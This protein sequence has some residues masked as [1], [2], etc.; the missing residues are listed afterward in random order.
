MEERSGRK[1]SVVGRMPL[2]T[3]Q[4]NLNITSISMPPSAPVVVNRKGLSLEPLQTN[5]EVLVLKPEMKKTGGSLS[6]SKQANIRRDLA[7]SPHI[8]E[9]NEIQKRLQDVYIKYE[10]DSAAPAAVESYDASRLVSL[11]NA[12]ENSQLKRV[13]VLQSLNKWFCTPD[14]GSV[15]IKDEQSENDESGKVLKNHEM[16]SVLYDA[17][18]AKSHLLDSLTHSFTTLE[19]HISRLNLGFGN[20]QSS[21]QTVYRMILSGDYVLPE[22]KPVVSGCMEDIR[23]FCTALE[24]D[25]SKVRQAGQSAQAT[26]G[27]V[28]DM[29][30]NVFQQ[31]SATKE[32]HQKRV[33]KDKE[34]SVRILKDKLENLEMLLEV[35]ERELKTM[36]KVNEK[37]K[38]RLE[39][40]II[41]RRRMS[42]SNPDDISM[43][44][45]SN[46]KTQQIDQV[47][48]PAG[49]VFLIFS[50]VS[51]ASR[52]WK[53]FPK[54]MT[55]ANNILYSI[56]ERICDEKSG[57]LVKQ[58]K[59][60]YLL[61]FTDALMAFEGIFDITERIQ[62]TSWPA[63]IEKQRREVLSSAMALKVCIVRGTPLVVL[64]RDTR[65]HEYI[66]KPIKRGLELLLQ[67]HADE[68]IFNERIG[69]DEVKN[70]IQAYVSEKLIMSVGNIGEVKIRGFIT[71]EN[72]LAL[73]FSCKNTIIPR[74]NEESQ[75]V[76]FVQKHHNELFQDHAEEDTGAY[77]HVQAV[78]PEKPGYMTFIALDIEEA[79]EF[80]KEYGE[81]KLI[82]VF[83][84]YSSKIESLVRKLG[85]Y[86]T[87]FTGT[88]HLF[89]AP[90]PIDAVRFALAVMDAMQNITLPV[91]FN[92]KKLLVR[93]AIHAGMASLAAN[94][95]TDEAQY[96]GT[97]VDQ[98]LFLC[99][100]AM[101]ED[102]L[103]TN[104]VMQEVL[105]VLT[106]VGS[107]NYAEWGVISKKPFT[108]TTKLYNIRSKSL[109]EPV[110][111]GDT[112]HSMKVT[113]S[114]LA[115]SEACFSL[116]EK[117]SS[118]V[119]SDTPTDEM[120]GPTGEICLVFTDVQD[121]TKLWEVYQN[122]MEKALFLHDDIMRNLID[123]NNGF[124]VKTEGD[125]FM[126]A[127][128]EPIDAL[129]WAM[130]AQLELLG[131]NWPEELL[132][133]RVESSAE[134]R[135][136]SGNLLYRGLRV[137]M[138]MH[139]G[140]PFCKL[141]PRTGRMDYFGPMVNRSARVSG[142]AQGGQ[143]VMSQRMQMEVKDQL[144]NIEIP[145]SMEL[146]GEFT[147]K[148]LD[149]PESIYQLLPVSLINRVFPKDIGSVD[150]S[151]Q[152]LME[153]MD[154]LA[155]KEE[156][157][158]LKR[159]SVAHLRVPRQSIVAPDADVTLVFT[160]VQNSTKLWEQYTRPMQAALIEHNGLM[161]SLI[162]QYNGY[163]VKTEGDAFMVA[164]SSSL[165][166][167]Q[168]CLAVQKELCFLHWPEDLL[169]SDDACVEYSSDGGI[170]WK[171]LRVRMGV[172]SGYPICSADPVTNR[173]D[174]FGPMVNRAARVSGVAKG[175]QIVISDRVYKE[176]DPIIRRGGLTDVDL[177]FLGEFQLKGL[178]TKEK[179]HQI[180]PT[181]LA[182]RRFNVTVSST[183]Q[184][185]EEKGVEKFITTSALPDM[186]SLA[187]AVQES[188]GI[189]EIVKEFDSLQQ[190]AR[191]SVQAPQEEAA[192]VVLEIENS[193]RVWAKN[194]SLMRQASAMVKLQWRKVAIRLGGY[195]IDILADS[196]MLGFRNAFSA[197]YFALSVQLA[198]H[199]FPWPDDIAAIPDFRTESKAGAEIFRG[200]KVRAAIHVGSS[201][202]ASLDD[203]SGQIQYW[204]SV[205]DHCVRI[206]LEAQGGQVLIS[207]RV[208][209]AVRETLHELDDPI[210][211]VLGEY[212]LQG[213]EDTEHLVQL[214][215][216]PLA[217][218]TFPPISE[219]VRPS[220]TTLSALMEGLME[221]EERY[222]QAV[223]QA[224][225][226]EEF[227]DVVGPS[228][229]VTLVF[230]DVQSSTK[231]WEK[232]P[233]EMETALDM[234]NSTL[235]AL[236]TEHNG[237]E[238]KTEGD[239]FMVAFGSIKD[240]VRW[241]IEAQRK[242]VHIPYPSAL[243]QDS[244]CAEERGSDNQ[245][246]HKGLR[247]RMGVHTGHPIIKVDPATHRLDYFGPM[248]NRAARVGGAGHGGQILV[249]RR[250]YADMTSNRS[251]YEDVAMIELGEFELKG[252]DT[253]ELLV[254]VLPEEF[255]ERQFPRVKCDSGVESRIDIEEDNFQAR[256]PRRERSNSLAPTNEVILVFTDVQ[257]S[258]KLWEIHKDIMHK[259]LDIHNM[260][261]RHCIDVCKGYEVKTEGDAFM[262]AFTD[263]V[264]AVKWCM[265]VQQAL[266]DADWPSEL[267]D[268]PDAGLEHDDEGNVIWR[269][270]RV[271]M[272]AHSGYPICAPDPKTGR[273]DYFGPMVNRAARVGGFGAGGQII[274]SRR[275]WKRA[276]PDR[277]R[278]GEFQ[279]RDLGKH[280]LKGLEEPEH[281]FQVHSLN[282]QKRE[283]ARKNEVQKEEDMGM[284]D[285]MIRK[286]E[287]NEDNDNAPE[288]DRDEGE[289]ENDDRKKERAPED[290][291]I[292]PELKRVSLLLFQTGK[293]RHDI[294]RRNLSLLIAR[295][296]MLELVKQINSTNDTKMV[297]A[298]EYRKGKFESFIVEQPSKLSVLLRKRQRNFK[299]IL[300]AL[301]PL[302]KSV[303][304]P[305]DVNLANTGTGY[306]TGASKR[307]QSKSKP[308]TKSSLGNFAAPVVRKTREELQKASGYK[309]PY[310]LAETKESPVSAPGPELM[311]P[312]VGVGGPSALQEPAGRGQTNGVTNSLGLLQRGGI[313]GVGAQSRRGRGRG[314]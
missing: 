200:P 259:A 65:Q 310:S 307:Y 42:L 249:S 113:S 171:G 102:I 258:T 195:E 107:P 28:N 114:L 288:D 137:R 37:T 73:S 110:W 60:F 230:T 143:V 165:K 297:K 62:A 179:I 265:D 151:S 302:A 18:V 285:K 243:F 59:D 117:M 312:A 123:Q 40:A 27:H 228:D 88:S 51:G 63:E 208:W 270:L 185:E 109:N 22:N 222:N 38:E 167:I 232:Y 292:D 118:Q 201:F 250:I 217:G 135:D 81:E 136:S 122:S 282:L 283:F 152:K 106:D 226:K 291:D 191:N 306:S 296:I 164:F 41:N 189:D 180:L 157:H 186:T 149:T 154:L 39:E 140:S 313:G 305:I 95:S 211:E 284:L 128:K 280:I 92:Q 300:D 111:N 264:E 193:E 182:E 121:S 177:L 145:V 174:Y 156:S 277:E 133:G 253:P 26:G 91:W 199:T 89:A 83:D 2:H 229:N 215:P 44:A 116:T 309:A 275:L 131:A 294:C 25:L 24:R 290:E 244:D 69:T 173:M 147:L 105:E 68:V 79:D 235:R 45:K 227:Q 19:E 132:D 238:V 43:N 29:M 139:L 76:R 220:G 155:Q 94:D 247:V 93:M 125:A 101:G 268:S 74:A 194:T 126:V 252:L 248:V 304:V 82:D 87:S 30:N 281:M 72:H 57:F 213:V 279:M 54:A 36:E 70:L 204:G 262:V 301:R 53:Q 196:M 161:R 163:E 119:E 71:N 269:G 33:Q 1:S 261:I 255:Q 159:M 49:E 289:K 20:M 90:L 241:T 267:L 251:D 202:N 236:I 99:R 134:M 85:V 48:L 192:F 257:N 210:V 183:E 233:Q 224:E 198:L 130:Q 286:N 23:T 13:R 78:V 142:K 158:K 314:R 207:R 127:F 260:V 115:M 141:D 245:L 46:K 176:I 150:H 96:C 6:N 295:R 52:K 162:V 240:A 56:I 103:V 205:V 203:K 178:D 170:L 77:G 266:L 169:H 299:L 175:G 278:I 219:L 112:E 8:Q 7:A 216:K 254:Q 168:W 11:W 274:I 80:R 104:A 221:N 206:C 146:V 187:Y 66:G 188:L 124:E 144:D 55:E 75:V 209:I 15:D 256:H 197:C 12:H 61:A 10:A 35:K 67:A 97:V 58:Q 4:H 47:E 21:F 14:S 311:S 308:G 3:R 50:C 32:A 287:G 212:K 231:L 225:D 190:R 120:Q 5:V 239:A 100:A 181:E 184:M 64:N 84:V 237:Y 218:R 293:L 129:K 31:L 108:K 214:V 138:G 148:G 271:R 166:S 172:H 98:T 242:L 263:P 16:D 17:N 234:H 272:G 223:V 276:E 160:D 273:M 9:L 246:I 303:D 86:Q 153:L 298:L 34:D